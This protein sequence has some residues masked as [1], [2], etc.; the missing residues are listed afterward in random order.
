VTN[1]MTRHS[2][3]LDLNR[4]ETDSKREV[5]Y[6]KSCRFIRAFSWM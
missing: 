2:I 4:S 5:V 6:F 1:E 3:M